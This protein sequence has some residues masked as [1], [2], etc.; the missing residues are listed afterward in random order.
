M[1]WLLHY[2]INDFVLLLFSL[3]TSGGP[4]GDGSV[5]AGCYSVCRWWSDRCRDDNRISV[6][7][8]ACVIYLYWMYILSYVVLFM[9]ESEM[10]E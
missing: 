2:G 3:L 7:W 1:W 9:A 5:A 4:L 8:D 6:F 10:T